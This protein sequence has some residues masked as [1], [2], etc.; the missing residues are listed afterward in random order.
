RLWID[1]TPNHRLRKIFQPSIDVGGEEF[2][3]QVLHKLF[4]ESLA[5]NQ[6][7]AQPILPIWV[8]LTNQVMD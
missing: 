3:L 6:A 7:S 5:Q 4:H 2:G 8:H 1:E